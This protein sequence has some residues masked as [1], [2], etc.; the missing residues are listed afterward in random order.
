MIASSSPVST[1]EVDG[2]LVGGSVAAGL[3]V[4]G[5]GGT[6]VD[7]SWS[8]SNVLAEVAMVSPDVSGAPWPW[9]VGRSAVSWLHAVTAI[10]ATNQCANG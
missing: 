8:P 9:T 2:A 5:G 1:P 10:A 4:V 7:V 3:L 6:V